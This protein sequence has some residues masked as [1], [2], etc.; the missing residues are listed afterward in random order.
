FKSTS[1]FTVHFPRGER[2]TDSR[3][4]SAI[5]PAVS[6]DGYQTQTLTLFSKY[7]STPDEPSCHSLYDVNPVPPSC[8]YI[9]N[10]CSPR[11]LVRRFQTDESLFP[12]CTMWRLLAGF[13]LLLCA[14]DATPVG[15]R[16]LPDF[17]K[18]YHVKGELTLPY[19]GDG[20]KE[21]F[22]VWYDLEGNRSRIDYHNRYSAHFSDWRRL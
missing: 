20:I 22:E 11:T 4:P 10:F 6:T 7:L 2:W 13:V 12:I 8:V 18:M 1:T 19:S 3:R 9:A 17:G 21:S 14:A 16:T 15:G 5:T